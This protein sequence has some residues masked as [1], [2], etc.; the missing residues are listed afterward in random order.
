M[1]IRQ[2]DR[3]PVHI[4]ANGL[5]I[6]LAHARLGVEAGDLALEITVFC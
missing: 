2:L 5:R 4:V 3:L 6:Q 1:F